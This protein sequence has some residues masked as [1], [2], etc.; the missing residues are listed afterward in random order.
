MNKIRNVKWAYIALSITFIIIGFSLMIWPEISAVTICII[1]GIALIFHGITKL[2]GYFSKD[3]YHL[4]FQ[5]D[6]ALGILTIL[7]GIVLII[8]PNYIITLLP[9]MIGLFIMINSVFKLQTSFDAK[10]FGM[11]KWWVMLTLSIVSALFGF[12]IV[13]N[14]FEGANLLMEIMGLS[15]VIDGIQNLSVA[16]YMIKVIKKTLPIDVEYIEKENWEA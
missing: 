12:L 1:I 7:F 15:L 5:F 6:L 2:M 3:P 11:S 9:I 13:I 10:R 4:V 8:H 14:P 16:L